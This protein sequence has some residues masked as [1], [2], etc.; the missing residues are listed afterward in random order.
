MNL[1]GGTP[2]KIATWRLRPA[3]YVLS[4][5]CALGLGNAAMASP[6]TFSID[7]S[8]DKTT[9]IASGGIEAYTPGQFSAALAGVPVERQ[10]GL[11][12]AIN[13]NGG[14]VAAAMQMDTNGR[15]PCG[16]DDRKNKCDF[17]K[18]PQP[19]VLPANRSK[20]FIQRQHQ[21]A[22]KSGRNLRRRAACNRNMPQFSF[23]ACAPHVFGLTQSFLRFD[24][25]PLYRLAETTIQR[26]EP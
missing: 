11:T 5:A 4:L 20:L 1:I 18:A 23:V 19:A 24:T 17:P 2:L 21:G 16:A 3:T 15:S 22:R 13:S 10:R 14:D 9:L 6:M 8:G 25:D 26:V 7:N 12:I